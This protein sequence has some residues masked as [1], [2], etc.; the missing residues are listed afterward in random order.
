MTDTR[1]RQPV[2]DMP[3]HPHPGQW[4]PLAATPKRAQP[5]PANLAT[6]GVQRRAVHGHAVVADVPADDT[7]QPRALL[8]GG[9][10]HASPQ[11][12]F[13]LLQLRLQPLANRL[14]KHREI[15]VT[16]LLPT[17]VC[18]AEEVKRLRLP[19]TAPSPV[20]GRVGTEF[21]QTGLLGMQLQM[22]FR[23]SFRELHPESFG[24]RLDLESEHDVIGIAH[25][26]DI[27]L[28][29]LLPPCLD[30]QVNT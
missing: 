14:P 4:M 27:A 29:T 24:I 17:N 25:D 9:T 22:E 6:E 10:V 5:E 8:A 26:D 30:P 18:E 21:Q 3:L 7:A 15:A 16:S 28:R 23:E 2:I 1:R 12:G 20:L 11:F 13:H 19:E